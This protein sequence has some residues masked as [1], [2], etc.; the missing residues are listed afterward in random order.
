MQLLDAKAV[1]HGQQRE[2]FAMS[3]RLSVS[4]ITKHVKND[5]W[6]T[7]MPIVEL[8]YSLLKPTDKDVIMC[9]FDT[10]KSNFVKYAKN[11]NLLVMYGMNDWLESDYEYDLL[12]TNPPFSIKDKV[13]EKCLETGLPSVLVLPIEAMGGVKR[14]ELYKTWGY[15][16]IYVPSRRINYISENGEHTKSNHFHSII[17]LLNDPLGSR[18][19]WE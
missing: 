19:L 14:H 8:M 9:P 13:I 6:Y 5:E 4:G 3:A 7:T 16:T 2:R 11:N 1:E 15:P 10:D 18:L 17:L 12:I